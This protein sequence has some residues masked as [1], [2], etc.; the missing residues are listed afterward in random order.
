M[1]HYDF[2]KAFACATL[3][4]SALSPTLNAEWVP[5]CFPMKVEEVSAVLKRPGVAELERQVLD[6]AKDSWCSQDK[7]KLLF[8]LVVLTQ[9]KVC[10]EIGSFTGSCTIPMAAGLRY[11]GQ[12]QAYVIDA[13]SSAEN[14]RGLPESD[15]NTQWWAGLD[16]KA[17]K[18]T[19][20]HWINYWSLGSYCQT[21]HMP[22]R[23]AVSKVPAI[24]FLHMDG[25]FSADGAELDAQLYIPKVV[26]GGYVLLSNALMMVDGHA[27]K[28]KAVKVLFKY[29]DLIDELDQ[30][31]TLLFRKK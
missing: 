12:G 26:S 7:A 5:R 1:K 10:V 2:A 25:N 3:L 15:V 19:Y 22:S 6:F 8:E 20:L 16:M 18:N 13:W 27:S 17:I 4:F 14:V 24:D 29:C 31:N 28:A 9:P 21:L 23:D 30:Q 11:L